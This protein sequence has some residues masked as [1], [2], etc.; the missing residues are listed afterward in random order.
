MIKLTRENLPWS[1]GD[2]ISLESDST[3]RQTERQY[4]KSAGLD[5]D[6][7]DSKTTMMSFSE[8]LTLV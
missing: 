8:V 7:I 2:T 1:A 5:L 4:A 3:T 6:Q